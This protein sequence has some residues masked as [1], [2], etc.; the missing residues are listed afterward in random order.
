MVMSVVTPPAELAPKPA[1]E[2]LPP[3]TDTLPVVVRVRL[4]GPGDVPPMPP[5]RAPPLVP[6]EPLPS[7]ATVVALIVWL[8][9]WMVPELSKPP[10]PALTWIAPAEICWV[11]V[12]ARARMSAEWPTFVAAAR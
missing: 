2:A 10:V 3:T 1:R 11:A 6:A 5:M 7:S 8:R 12:E 9:A 4:V